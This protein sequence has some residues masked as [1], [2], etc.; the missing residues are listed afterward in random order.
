MY[1][2]LGAG[3]ITQRGRLPGGDAGT[4]ATLGIMRRLALE[5]A[6]DVTVRETAI[7]IVRGA[8]AA[9]HDSLAELRALFTF[10]RDRVRFTSDI[11]GVE[12][13]QGP[14]Y[15]LRVM[16]GDCDDRATLLVALA[17]SIGLP[18]D[19]KFR[20]VAVDKRRPG[21]FSHVYV[22]GVINGRRIA[23]DPTYST[24]GLGWEYPHPFRA[25]EVSA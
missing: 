3:K 6:Q 12:T 14:R 2:Q 23:L 20:A 19:L 7:A 21:S 16:A 15:T 17:R 5:G 8:N 22:V 9:G 1:E 24:N 13:L 18:V 4:A 25:S 10:V 11:L